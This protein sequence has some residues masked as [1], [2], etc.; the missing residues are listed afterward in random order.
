MPLGERVGHCRG[1]SEAGQ[2]AA[3]VQ[4]VASSAACTGSEAGSLG[5][6]GGK[7]AGCLC[8][9]DSSRT[10]LHCSIHNV[11]WPWVE[12]HTTFTAVCISLH[13]LFAKLL[14]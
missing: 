13:W 12:N 9:K 11:V 6:V 5:R 2:A 10:C 8:Q 3:A 14:G 1:G 7:Q 4:P